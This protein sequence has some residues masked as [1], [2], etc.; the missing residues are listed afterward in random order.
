MFLFIK[1]N[2]CLKF[3]KFEIY[4]LNKIFIQYNK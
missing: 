2:M 1:K 4:A 3:E